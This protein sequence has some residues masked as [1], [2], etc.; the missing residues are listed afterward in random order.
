MAS[1]CSVRTVPSHVSVPSGISTTEDIS[2][3]HM[4]IYLFCKYLLTTYY[5]PDM[6]LAD[7]DPE[8][9]KNECA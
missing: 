5:V 2:A 7:W 1:K 4:F 8:V 9:I 6:V 3:S